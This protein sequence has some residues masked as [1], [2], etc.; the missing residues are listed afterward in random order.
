MERRTFL[1]WLTHGLGAAFAATLGAPAALFLIDPRNRPT[2]PSDFRTVAKRGELKIGQ[3]FQAIIRT[4]R[5]D[6]WTLHPNDVIGRVWL[7]RRDETKIDAYTTICP[8]LGCSVNFIAGNDAG[9]SGFFQ[10]PCH[11][12]TFD[13]NCKKKATTP[14]GGNNPAPRDMDSLPVQLV[15][16]DGNPND[17]LVQVKYQ[18]FIQGLA[19]KIERT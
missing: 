7:I 18:N 4:V 2:P 8:H 13:M 10:C 9:D 6:A 16:D 14:Q 3:P 12:G 1:K 17:Q 19:E 11:N 5:R 15:Q